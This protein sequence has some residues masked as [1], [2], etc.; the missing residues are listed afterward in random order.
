MMRYPITL[1]GNPYEVSRLFIESSACALRLQELGKLEE[2]IEQATEVILKK[3]WF[4][5]GANEVK[6]PETEDS[7]SRR[8]Q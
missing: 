7:R 6:F 3:G 8:D 2:S 5:E 1:K 4:N